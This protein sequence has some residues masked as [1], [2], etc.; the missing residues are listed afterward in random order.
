MTIQI[1]EKEII[2]TV[3]IIGI[4]LQI[5]E[6]EMIA[7]SLYKTNRTSQLL[8]DING[9]I[10]DGTDQIAERNKKPNYNVI[11]KQELLDANKKCLTDCD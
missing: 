5:S 11:N 4:G 10:K 6:L 1:V 3:Y 9:I 2:Q 8:Q 7:E